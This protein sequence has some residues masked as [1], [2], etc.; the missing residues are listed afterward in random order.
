M[1]IACAQRSH[2]GACISRASRLSPARLSRARPSLPCSAP[3]ACSELLT[4]H[5]PHGVLTAAKSECSRVSSLADLARSPCIFPA[6]TIINWL[7]MGLIAQNHYLLDTDNAP[8]WP[9]SCQIA[10]YLDIWRIQTH[11]LNVADGTRSRDRTRDR[12]PAF[13]PACPHTHV[14]A[15]RAPR[16]KVHT[17]PRVA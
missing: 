9:D 1:K 5:A 3:H 15:A 10:C 6:G 13:R 8:R 4:G 14:G 12:T 7:V 2:A 16:R 17:P 11:A